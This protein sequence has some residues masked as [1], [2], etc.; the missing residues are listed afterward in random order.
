[1]GEGRQSCCFFNKFPGERGSVM[2]IVVMQQSILLLP[3]F[4]AKS[5]YIFTQLL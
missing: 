2:C 5:L 3:K 4:W 1:M